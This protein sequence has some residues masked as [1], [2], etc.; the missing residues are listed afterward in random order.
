MV[1]FMFAVLLFFFAF[2]IASSFTSAV[3]TVR[4]GM[5]CTANFSIMDYGSKT[6]CVMSDLYSPIFIAI[7]IGVAGALIAIKIGI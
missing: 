7:I 3:Q 6:V 1:V 4:T 2:T 5:A